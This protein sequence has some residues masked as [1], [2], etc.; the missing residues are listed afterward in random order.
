MENDI[1]ERILGNYGKVFGIRRNRF[2][3][4]KAEGLLNGTRTARMELKRSIPSSLN[5]QGHNVVL[6][7]SG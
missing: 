5:I 6:Y 2:A 1:L 7:H 4:G 3:Y